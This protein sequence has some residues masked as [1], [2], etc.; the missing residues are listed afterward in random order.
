MATI[1]LSGL[2]L[3]EDTL[4]LARML[5]ETTREKGKLSKGSWQLSPIGFK[6]CANFEMIGFA[7]PK[8]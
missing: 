8:S 5:L 2:E 3:H 1:S 7:V 6:E 4:V